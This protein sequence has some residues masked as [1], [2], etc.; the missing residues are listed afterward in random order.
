MDSLVWTQSQCCSSYTR[1]VCVCVCLSGLSACLI[2]VFFSLAVSI[3]SISYLVSGST[4]AEYV[5][6]LSNLAAS[7]PVLWTSCKFMMALPFTYHCI[8]GLRH[9]VSVHCC[10]DSINACKHVY[11]WYAL[12]HMHTS[13]YWDTGRGLTTQFTIRAGYAVLVLAILSA[14]GLASWTPGK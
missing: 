6:S 7:S 10:R 5:S 13:Q 1:C 2:L 4:F 14:F 3:I 12:P 9:L 8:N 11:R